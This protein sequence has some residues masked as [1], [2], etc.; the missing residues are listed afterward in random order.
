[1]GGRTWNIRSHAAIAVVAALHVGLVFILII[2]LRTPMQRGGDFVTTLIFLSPHATPAVPPDSGRSP[3]VP[4][5]ITPV[6]PLKPPPWQLGLPNVP[7]TSIDWD[8]EGKRAAGAVTRKSDIR[9]FGQNP[10]THLDGQNSRPGTPHEA[11]E[12]Y[13]LGDEWIVWVGPGC[14]IVSSVPPLGMPDVL[15]RSI[16]TR[17]VCQDNTKPPGELFKD[18]PAFRK[19]HPQ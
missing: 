12:Q 10:A 18:L 6:E 16:P 9:E 14:Y 11:G 5:P 3:F 4:A 7:D 1:M 13:R 15:A 19:Y 2:A 8:S 17:T